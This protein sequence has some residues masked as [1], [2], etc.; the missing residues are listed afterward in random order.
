MY[1]KKK[2]ILLQT[3]V[4]RQ[5]SSRTKLVQLNMKKKSFQVIFDSKLK[6]SRFKEN[7]LPFFVVTLYRFYI[8][9]KYSVHFVI[10]IIIYH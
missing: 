10:F 2:P 3:D 6:L 9:L 4:C 7:I 8:E 1:L 5:Y